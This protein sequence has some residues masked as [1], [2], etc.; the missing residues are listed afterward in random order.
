[1]W[2]S[3]HLYYPN[4]G[5]DHLQ[6]FENNRPAA[7]LFCGVCAEEFELKSSKKPFGKRIVD[8]A[9]KTMT[10]RLASTSNPN[11]TLL[12]YDCDR[13]VVT[14]LIMVPKHFFTSQII[15]KRPPLGPSARRAGWVGCNILYGRV[16]ETGKISVI[17]GGIVTPR[18]EVVHQW[19]RSMFLR[20]RTTKARG[21]LLEIMREIE[22]L[23]TSEFTINQAYG[24]ERGLK[25]LYPRNQ[26]IKEKIRQQLQVL[27]DNGW[28]EFTGRG[29]YRLLR[30]QVR[31]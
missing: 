22:L 11:L 26:H 13:R 12:S 18:E 29:R 24:F 8:G 2:A 19:S 28:L 4:C 6:P 27:R 23:G 15:E 21:W 7:D 25:R 31:P 30:D 3:T 14:D 5:A 1:M 9:Y 16:P 17:K 20:D 10:Q